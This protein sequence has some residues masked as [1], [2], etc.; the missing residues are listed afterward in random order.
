MPILTAGTTLDMTNV[1]RDMLAEAL[2]EG[3]VESFTATQVTVRWNYDGWSVRHTFTG[4]GF[5]TPDADGF[6][7][8]GS[9]TGY[10]LSYFGGDAIF[11]IT[12]LSI[13]VAQLRAALD[14]KSVV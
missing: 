3:T 10:A 1:N 2:S 5:G 11:S 7:T 13:T 4:T 8:T 12:G 14:R 9:I 6:P